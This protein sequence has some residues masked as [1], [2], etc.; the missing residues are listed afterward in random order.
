MD[1]ELV[2]FI[3]IFVMVILPFT[4]ILFAIGSRFNELDEEIK[5]SKNRINKLNEEIKELKRRINEL[6]EEIQVLKNNK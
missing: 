3:I 5:E 1:A 6:E 4:I 2:K